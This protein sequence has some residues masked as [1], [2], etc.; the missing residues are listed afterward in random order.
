M[1]AEKADP[2]MRETFLEVAV[3]W[4]HMA[5]EIDWMYRSPP[6]PDPKSE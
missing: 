3:L 1:L 6:Y 5:E 4:W 2:S